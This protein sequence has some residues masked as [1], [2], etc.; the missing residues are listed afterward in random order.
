MITNPLT[1]DVYDKTMRWQGRITDPVSIAGS[2]RANALGAFEYR[3]RATDP[4]A[5]DILRKGTR[6]SMSYLGQPLMS[7]MV[8][9]KQGSL[10]ASGDLVFQLQ[11][12][13]R[14]LVNTLALVNPGNVLMPTSL[15]ATTAAGWAQASLPGGSGDAGA[16]GTI[17]GQSGFYQWA[18]TI[19]TAE[20]AIKR[21]IADN[22]RDRLGR[23]VTIKP[24]LSRGGDAAA[25][26]MLPIVRNSNV[27]EAVQALLDWSGLVLKLIQRPGTET[28]EVDVYEPSVWAAPL[29]VAS[30]IVPDGLWTMAPPLATRALVGGPGEGPARAFWEERDTGTLE[31][32]YGDIIEVFRDATGAD[33]KWPSTLADT[34][35]VAKYYLLRPEVSAAAKT[36]LSNYLAA[37]GRKGLGEGKA[38]TSVSATLSET[39]TF[40][41]GGVDGIQLG[42]LVNVTSATGSVF[43]E[44]ITEASF[45]LAADGFSV[46]PILGDKT[47]STDRKLATAIAKLAASQRKLSASR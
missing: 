19:S 46:Q 16:D 12:D 26:G 22:L 17:Q 25:A 23:N 41:F 28:V 47:G 36:A 9:A 38:T 32:D 1:C 43:V 6:I 37:A 10:L 14:W 5:E 27:A 15:S 31:A 45:T 21:I 39:E 40:H 11:D 42:D 33:L 44:R 13:W 20:G 24:N 8:R 3:I 34:Y 2:V 4:M 29:T 7:G 18:G 30:G 35:R